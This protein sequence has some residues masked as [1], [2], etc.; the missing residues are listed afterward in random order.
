M[1]EILMISL[2]PQ[3]KKIINK[4]KSVETIKYLKLMGVYL[5]KEVLI[6][7]QRIALWGI[8]TIVMQR[9]LNSYNQKHLHQKLHQKIK[10]IRLILRKKMKKDNN[11]RETTKIIR[12]IN[13]MII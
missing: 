1:I 13:R 7:L 11:L 3:G 8:E 5:Q 12:K 2:N 9:Y 6:V 10:R 4:I